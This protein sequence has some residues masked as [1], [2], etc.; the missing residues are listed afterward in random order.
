MPPALLAAPTALPPQQTAVGYQRLPT[1]APHAPSQRRAEQERQPG[2]KG[3]PRGNASNEAARPAKMAGGT[4]ERGFVE[5]AKEGACD[6][7]RPA[8]QAL[9]SIPVP[10]PKEAVR[11]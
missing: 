1:P 9:S 4:G 2:D 3:A 10:P 6:N 11:E 7:N 5:E 8:P